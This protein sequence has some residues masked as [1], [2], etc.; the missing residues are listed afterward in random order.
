MITVVTNSSGSATSSSAFTVT[1][2]GG[3]G[4]SV[5]ISQVYGGGASGSASYYANDY[6]ELYNPTASA[7][8]LS[9][10]SVQY[11]SAG[12]SSY[13]LTKLTGSI[14]AGHYYLVSESAG[15]YGRTLPTPDA[16]GNFAMAKGAGK[17]ALVSKQTA[18]TS[19]TSTGV[20]DYVGYGTTAN[21]YEGSGPA[22]ELSSTTADFRAGNGA[23][24]TNNNA[25]DFTAGTPNPRNSAH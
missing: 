5:V 16:S 10:Y 2:S 6:I 4:T 8:D 11:A 22:P 15:N 7:V 24:D 21:A 25:A 1:T 19:K 17:V 14:A 13:S 9:T 20:V 12:G 23:T 3:T 18:I